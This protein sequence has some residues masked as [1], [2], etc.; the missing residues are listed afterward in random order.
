MR[1]WPRCASI[2]SFHLGRNPTRRLVNERITGA[3]W[4]SANP[5]TAIER[6][7]STALGCIGRNQVYRR[8]VGHASFGRDGIV[9]ASRSAI[10]ADAYLAECRGQKAG[11]KQH[12]AGR[13][14]GKKS[15][16]DNVV[17]AHVT[18]TTQMLVRIY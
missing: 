7:R 11:A 3:A 4:L 15:V 17:V 12:E 13:C 10:E 1:A 2:A 6:G 18:P 8:F 14:E 5:V 16:G 9:P